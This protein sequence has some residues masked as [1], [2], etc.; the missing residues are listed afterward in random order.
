MSSQKQNISSSFVYP[1]WD[2][3]IRMVDNLVPALCIF[4][5]DKEFT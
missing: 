5:N 4:I 3:E 2:L 1:E